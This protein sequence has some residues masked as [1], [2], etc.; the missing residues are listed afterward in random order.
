M[1]FAVEVEA[2]AIREPNELRDKIRYLFALAKQSIEEELAGGIQP[3]TADHVS[4][5]NNG[6]GR[7]QSNGRLATAS[8]VRAI[9]AI[10][11]RNRIEL[12]ARLRDRFGVSKPDDL[13]IGQASELIDELKAAGN[14]EGGRR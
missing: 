8:Q 5:D 10:A 1:N 12:S 11:G 4:N 2:T 13:S 14:G 3:D 7:N 9:H 6:H